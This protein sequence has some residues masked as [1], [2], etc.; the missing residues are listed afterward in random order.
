MPL[1]KHFKGKGEEVMESMKEEYG[2]KEGK[3]V[4]YATDNKRKNKEK[5][6][7]KGKK[8]DTSPS[9]KVRAKFY[10]KD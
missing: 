8:L 7:V 5:K 1:S 9:K 4:F 10:L 6:E 3:K 2:E